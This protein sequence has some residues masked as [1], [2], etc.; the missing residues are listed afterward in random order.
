MD[1]VHPGDGPSVYR[2]V[3]RRWAGTVRQS[4][5]TVECRHHHR[6]REL[7]QAPMTSLFPERLV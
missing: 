2:D 4:G 6:R 7:D 1:D 3:C 5:R